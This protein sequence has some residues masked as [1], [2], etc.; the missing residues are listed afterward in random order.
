MGL[1]AEGQWSGA[2]DLYLIAR[3]E[4]GHTSRKMEGEKKE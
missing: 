2:S 4:V 3:F 1:A